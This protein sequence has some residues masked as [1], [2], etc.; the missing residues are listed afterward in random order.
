MNRFA[1][2]ALVLSASLSVSRSALAQQPTP[3]PP[4]PP[5]PT[6]SPMVAADVEPAEQG[7][8]VRWGVNARIGAFLPQTSV[9]FGLE[10]RVGYSFNPYF[11]LY[12]ETG[13]VAGFGVGAT[14]APGA[15]GGSGTLNGIAIWHVGVNAEATI[16][17]HFYIAAGPQ[18]VY[19]GW[20]GV[21]GGGSV[22]GQ[23]FVRTVASG[24]V[25]PGLDMKLGFMTGKLRPNGGRRGFSIGVQTMLLFQFNAIYASALIGGGAQFDISQSFLLGVTPMLMLGYDSL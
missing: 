7:G 18:F 2:L 20:G 11:A 12:G 6:Q 24:G 9:V 25:M 21:T 19:G 16:A 3:P 10:G 23:T 15:T 8:H 4:P 17:D 14:V 1:L 13:F 5:Q 22:N